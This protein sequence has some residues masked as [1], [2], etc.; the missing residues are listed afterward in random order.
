MSKH[1]VDTAYDEY[2]SHKLREYEINDHENTCVLPALG[3]RIS[4]LHL[5]DSTK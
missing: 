2:Y 1:E 4:A 3:Q 5:T